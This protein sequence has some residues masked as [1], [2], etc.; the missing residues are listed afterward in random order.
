MSKLR[1]TEDFH[2][3]NYE[4]ETSSSDEERNNQSHDFPD[5]E[6][7]CESNTYTLRGV[8]NKRSGS[9]AQIQRGRKMN[10]IS[11]PDEVKRTPIDMEIPQKHVQSQE[12]IEIFE[13]HSSNYILKNIEIEIQNNVLHKKTTSSWLM[14]FLSKNR[15]DTIPSNENIPICSN[16][17]FEQFNKR[18]N[19]KSS[20][21]KVE[22]NEILEDMECS[23]NQE[24]SKEEFL[25][26][27]ADT[28]NTNI[29]DD[30]INN[31]NSDDVEKEKVQIKLFNL[32]YTITEEE[33]I[34]TA[35]NHGIIFTHVILDTNKKTNTPAGSATIELQLDVDVDVADV[36]NKLY[37]KSFGGRPV[38]VVDFKKQKKNRNSDVSRYFVDAIDCKCIL[39]GEVG[40][41]QNDCTKEPL[42]VPCH[43]CASSQHEPIDCPNLICFRCGDFGHHSR[44][45][46]NNRNGRSIICTACG[47]T[48]HDAKNCPINGDYITKSQRAFEESQLKFVDS[49]VQCMQCNGYGHVL[50]KINLPNNNSKIYCP[51]C[52][53]EGHHVDYLSVD[54]NRCPILCQVP[55]YEAY[56]KYNQLY[57]V[58]DLDD[59][60][61]LIGYTMVAQANHF[62][63]DNVSY[64]FPFL[65]T[66]TP[67]TSAASQYHHHQQQQQ[68]RQIQRS[69]SGVESMHY[70]QR[71]NSSGGG[72]GGSSG[73]GEV[74][75]GGVV[76]SD[77]WRDRDRDTAYIDR[78]NNRQYVDPLAYST[79]N[80][81]FVVD[82][83]GYRGGGCGTRRHSAPEDLNY[84]R[85]TQVQT[86][87]SQGRNVSSQ[88]TTA[89]QQ[90]WTS[91]RPRYY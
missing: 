14:S 44:Y 83:L 38:R 17:F 48:T 91:G 31:N 2:R 52:G 51:N 57:K 4:D 36:I 78:N 11:E 33:I 68:Q 70:D 30:N 89:R 20:E 77:S 49:N 28:T 66:S 74:R 58:L 12:I 90:N 39:C 40:H 61:Q 71:R 59:D 65:M 72:G 60:E 13:T 27:A 62:T 5:D 32:P 75:R 9:S 22:S 43:L 54:K 45:C 8:N 24:Y 47:N 69:S 53:K 46:T 84:R 21:N 82:N 80:G 42:P 41:K 34:N 88:S 81:R 37:E 29:N 63:Q 35:K 73:S 3:Q 85:H 87:S 64:L 23:M 7:D 25:S 79:S 6:N 86:H 1:F 56:L 55:R 50:C 76:R 15:D 10:R 18:F 67:T 16:E 19:Q 26:S